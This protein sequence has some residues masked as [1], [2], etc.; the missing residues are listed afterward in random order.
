M[1]TSFNKGG[2]ILVHYNLARGVNLDVIPTKQFKANQI[3][4]NFTTPQTPTNATARNLVANVLETSSKKYPT[5]TALARRLA[6]QYGTYISMGVGRVGLLHTVRLKAGFIND[7]LAHTNLFDQVIALIREILFNPL[8]SD[9]AFDQA[10]FTRQAHNLGATINSYY[11][12]K[13][14]WAARRLLDLYYADDSVMQTPSFGKASE[15]AELT[16]QNLYPVY[17]SMIKDDRVDILVI[18]DLDEQDVI[19][20]MQQLPFS[21]RQIDLGPIIYG[22]HPYRQIQRQVEY[23]Q[24]SQAKLNLGYQLPIHY[25]HALYYAGLVFNGLFGGSPY[26]KLFTNVREKASL[27]YYAS[28]RLMPFNGLLTVQTGINSRDAR[29]VE[30]LINA[31]LKDIQE[32]NY[33][34]QRLNEVK[35]GLI[36]QYRSGNDLAG[37]LLERQLVR[38]LLGVQQ[39]DIPAAFNAVTRAEIQRVAQSLKQQAVYLLSGEN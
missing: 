7:Q 1:Q 18:G 13:Q 39:A 36:N 29:R 30:T 19:S 32:D 31:Q 16:A 23:Q 20:A 38:N 11:D 4:I 26:S 34:D 14:F 15:I 17:Q 24:L 8:A 12:D 35:A 5:Q 6:Q 10:T 28:S 37:N 25:G 9:G 33:S 3:L 2:T 22:Q 27:A 21:D